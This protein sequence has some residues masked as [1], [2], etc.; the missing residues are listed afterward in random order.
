MSTPKPTLHVLDDT[1]ST[2]E[3]LEKSTKAL[4]DELARLTPHFQEL[5]A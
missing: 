4:L 3:N 5:R 1:F 2:D